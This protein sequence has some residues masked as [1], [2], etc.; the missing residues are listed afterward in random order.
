[1]EHVRLGIVMDIQAILGRKLLINQMYEIMNK[2]A[3]LS[4]TSESENV[5][6]QCRKVIIILSCHTSLCCHGDFLKAVLQFLLDY[7]LKK[8]LQS[9]LNLFVS[10]LRLFQQEDCM[11]I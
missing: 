1:M 10:N 5:Q 3:H 6:L 9:Y 11:L 4:I 7:P 2:V 8:K